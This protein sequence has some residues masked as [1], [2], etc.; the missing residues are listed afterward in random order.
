VSIWTG[1]QAKA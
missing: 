1:R